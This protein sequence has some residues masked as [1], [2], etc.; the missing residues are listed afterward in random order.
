L[1]TLPWQHVLC[2][3]PVKQPKAGKKHDMDH[4]QISALAKEISDGMFANSPWYW[5]TLIAVLALGFYFGPM[6]AAI[7][8][9]RGERAIT[10]DDFDAL[11]RELEINT[12]LVA[13]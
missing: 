4:T 3:L 12:R 13:K 1:L 9:G 8:K 2:G 5:V 11:K 7:G 10:K 6:I